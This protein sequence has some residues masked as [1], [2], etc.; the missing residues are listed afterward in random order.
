M[1]KIFFTNFNKL[2]LSSKISIRNFSQKEN[3]ISKF[4][5]SQT[6]Y[7]SEE[8]FL[9]DENDNFIQGIS[10]LDGKNFI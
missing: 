1:R 5:E 7:F 8:L 4:D 6:K 3:F 10:K 2:K 9:V